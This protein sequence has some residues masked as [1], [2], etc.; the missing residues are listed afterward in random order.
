MVSYRL[1]AAKQA[2]I[3][4][5]V[6]ADVQTLWNSVELCVCGEIADQK[7]P[8]SHGDR[9][10]NHRDE[11]PTDSSRPITLA[12]SY[13]RLAEPHLGLSSDRCSTE[14]GKCARRL[15]S[16]ACPLDSVRVL[17]LKCCFQFWKETHH[18]A[19]RIRRIT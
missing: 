1:E 8:P 12:G 18:A 15:L 9:T 19:G 7:H 13:P 10:E 5:L 16:G 11:F 14:L 4:N 6:R 2:A 17:V 3:E